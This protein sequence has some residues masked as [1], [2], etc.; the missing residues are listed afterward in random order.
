MGFRNPFRVQVDENDVA[1]ISDYS[2]DANTPSRSRGPAGTGRYQIVRAPA[3]YGW[4]A[5]YSKTLG[6]YEW[7]YHEFAAGTTTAGKPKHD[8]PRHHVCD[9]A[10]Q[11][12]DS[13]WN[14]E[15]GPGFEA[16]LRELPPVTNPDIWYS[17]QDNPNANRALGTPCRGYHDT[18][19]G[20]PGPRLRHR[21][22]R[23]FPELFTG[24]VAARTASRSTTST[25]PTRTPRSS[26]I[27]RRLGDPG[28]VRPG[29]DA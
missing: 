26:R 22:P 8:P 25:P 18:T 17:Y 14:L 21:C 6:Y 12:N 4:P 15:G 5:C 1:Y 24:G 20:D 7:E 13:R 28:R 23:L 29:H 3:N 9:G 11:L 19:P 27:R 16:G 2:P 10:T